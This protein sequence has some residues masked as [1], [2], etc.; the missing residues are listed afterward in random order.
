MKI[1]VICLALCALSWSATAQTVFNT[2]PTRAFGPARL[3]NPVTAASPNSVDGRDL[4]APTATALDRSA[5]PPIL[6]VVDTNNNRVLG[7]KNSGAF[8]NGDPADII[9][10]QR[11]KYSTLPKGP[12]TDLTGGLNSPSAVAVDARGN[13]YV[14]DGGNNRI[15]RYP[16]PSSATGTTLPDLVIGQTSLSSG[17]TQNQGLS[18]PSEKTL[19]LGQG[20]NSFLV[21]MAFDA[22]GNLWVTDYGNNR[23]LRYSASSLSAGGSVGADTVLGQENMT[24]NAAPSGTSA[25]TY[26]KAVIVRPTTLGLSQNGDLYV[27]DTYGRVLFFRAGTQVTG[28]SATR[29]LGL[30]LPNRTSPNQTPALYGCVQSSPDPACGIRLGA[31]QG[32]TL[33][34]APGGVT[35]IANKAYVADTGNSRV[36]VYD[37]PDK[38]ITECQYTSGMAAQ[39][40]AANT[41]LSPTPVGYIGQNNSPTAVKPNQGLRMPSATTLAAP[42]GLST[43]G[44]DLYVADE[45]NNRVLLLP[46]AGQSASRVLGQNDF[47]MAAR[48]LIE[49]RELNLAG[50]VAIT[51]SRSLLVAGTSAI[52]ANS[53]PPHLYIADT[54]NHRILGFND[55]RKM[56]VGAR[57][58]IVIGQAD[59][60]H[61]LVNYESQDA[62]VPS[63]SGL[64]FPTGLTVDANGDLW[65]ADTFNGRV[66]RFPKPFAQTGKRQA[67]LVLGKSAFTVRPGDQADTTQ[68]TMSYP[69]GLAAT[70]SGNIAVSD[71][72][73][74]RVL[75]FRKPQG[76]DFTN[77][78]PANVVIGQPDFISFAGG[79]Q[80]N[81]FN[82]PRGIAFDFAERLY[83]ADAGNNRV[84]VFSRTGGFG[85]TDNPSAAF[86]QTVSGVQDIAVSLHTGEIWV[87]NSGGNQVVRFPLYEQWAANPTGALTTLSTAQPFSVTLDP[88]DNPVVG[89]SYQRIASYF[90]QTAFKNA[91]SYS[92]RALT[93]GMLA[94]MAPLGPG[95]DAP[96]AVASA[97]PF[98][99][100]LSD[101]QVTVSAGGSSWAAPIYYVQGGVLAIQVPWEAPTSGTA[102]FVITRASTG[103]VLS[104]A[105]LPMDVAAPAIFTSN[106][107]GSGQVAAL[108]EDG[109]VNGPDHP[110]QI[111]HWVSI[112]GTGIGPVSG[113]PKT[114]EPNP[115]SAVPA[116]ELPQ[117][118]I[119]GRFVNQGDILYFGLA[120]GLVG[121]FQ[122]N[123]R[124]TEPTPAGNS[125]LVGFF[126][127]DIQSTYGPPQANGQPSLIRTTIAV[128]Q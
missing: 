85:P 91:A 127:K 16:N 110:V 1:R 89:D 2:L 114:G 125:I 36:V 51:S 119:N 80:T 108:N 9:V 7:W 48:N 90:P 60:N 34:T 112:F 4:N 25:V 121:G 87:T 42:L 116:P 106:L 11:D 120:P 45:G 113:S 122:L 96:D 126:Y 28:G 102:D 46:G 32:T 72:A 66:L 17:S 22:N 105:S 128:K 84:A 15:L 37:S 92:S 71:L 75:I 57:A 86:T 81:R 41:A 76:G 23:V 18:A 29:L 82:G 53:D 74:N 124:V 77:G 98:P 117:V 63:A 38:W 54:L 68:S 115:S 103:Q 24:S 73:F 64:A 58:D 50:N 3:T 39:D 10:G 19:F 55:Y 13:V 109:T 118:V 65:V 49:G 6:Y 70:P 44:T 31:Y 123:V 33:A 59:F 88:Y 20:G 78:Q 62:G 99:T 43:N 61:A 79:N 40:C 107:Q 35:V 8:N 111:G 21:G 97:V 27:G 95:V 47:S 93:P 14:A 56:T 52:D 30:V 67:N 5:N 104:A 94:I 12:G 101:L 26:N 100:V 69:Y 83:V